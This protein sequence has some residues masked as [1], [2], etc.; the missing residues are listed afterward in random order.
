MNPGTHDGRANGRVLLARLACDFARWPSF[1]NRL[2]DE[3]ECMVSVLLA[4]ALSRLLGIGNVGWAAFSAYMVIRASFADS[5][6]RGCLRVLGTAVGASLAWLLAPELLR[7]T[8]MLSAALA[9][10]GAITLYL[11]LLDRSGYGWLFAGLTFAMVL[12]DGMEHRGLPLG[13]FAQSRF[14]EVL[15]GT[16]VSILVSAVSALT[17][18]RHLPGASEETAQDVVQIASQVGAQVGAQDGR[19]PAMQFCHKAAFRHAL[20]GAIAL[21]LVPWAWTA[22]HIEALGQ[23]SITI[24]V[25]MMVPMA[26]LVASGYPASTRLRHRFYGGCVGGLLATGI[27]VL[28]HDSPLIMTLAVCLG[29]MVG[30]HIENGRLGISYAGTQFALAFLVVL[31]PDCYTGFHAAAGFERLL[32]I[33]LG[34]ALLEPLRLLFG[35]GN[36]GAGKECRG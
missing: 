7:S 24:M 31:V 15:V 1:G 13:A 9:L 5:L 18:R 4:I 10:F 11:A 12:V 29:L 30:R 17:V 14:V 34:I 16:G 6:R 36:A 32:G 26:D 21:A 33:V 23:S 2:V 35:H 8:A 22:F 19:P 3:I 27:L 20:Q 25:V 28:S